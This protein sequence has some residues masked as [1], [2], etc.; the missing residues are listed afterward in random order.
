MKKDVVLV[1]GFSAIILFT[2]AFYI[3]CAGGVNLYTTQDDI[4]LGEQ[5]KAEIAKNPKNYPVLNDESIRSYVQGIENKVRSSSIFKNSKI[6]KNDVTIIKDDKTVNAFCIPGGA[7]Y[8][9][10]GLLKYIDDEATLAGILGHET[11]HGDHRHSTQQ[12]TKQAGIQTAAGAVL[13]GT[14]A[15]AQMAAN[16][17]ANLTFLSFSRS[18]ESDADQTSFY[19]LNSLPG[20]PWYPA[21]IKYF[22]EK[23]LKQSGKTDELSKLL[24]THPASEDRLAAVEKLAKKENLPAPTE[25]N[26]NKTGYQK[27][28]AKLP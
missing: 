20:K 24:Q 1:Q 2:V 6:F 26:L 17:G 16:I 21:A 23:T 12:M 11:T 25:A 7:V 22:M 9:Y 19:A 8:V 27:F 4:Q 13:G 18:D 10:T 15:W 3:G 28:R 5:M 14:P